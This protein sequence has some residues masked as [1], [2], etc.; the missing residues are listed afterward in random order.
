LYLFIE[1]PFQWENTS[2][3][4]RFMWWFNHYCSN[5]A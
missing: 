4:Q 2:G 1:K 5:V 3:Y